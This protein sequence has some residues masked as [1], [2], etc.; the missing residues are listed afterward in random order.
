MIEN[1]FWRYFISFKIPEEFKDIVGNAIDIVACS[2]FD[3]DN[4]EFHEDLLN[5]KDR[6][7]G[8][9]VDL[10]D[11]GYESITIAS[12]DDLSNTLTS[13]NGLIDACK[14]TTKSDFFFYFGLLNKKPGIIVVR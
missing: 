4:D 3:F 13:I 11:D 8:S 9:V 10:L 6:E 12:L 2:D 7:G 14:H 5:M 1:T